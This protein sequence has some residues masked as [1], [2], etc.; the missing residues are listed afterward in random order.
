MNNFSE[1]AVVILNYNGRDF[2][3]KYLPSVIQ[4]SGNAQIIVADN[5][6]TDDSLEV[7]KQDFPEINTIILPENYWFAKGYNQALQQVEA[8]YFVLLNSDVRVTE[9]WLMPMLNLLES[10]S[11]IAA[12]Q[13]KILDDK[14]PEYFEY[15]SPAGG[16]IDYLGYPF[17]R[18]R[19][20][21]T[22]E[23]DEQQYNDTVEVFWACGAC[24]F[25]RADIFREMGGFD[26]DFFA[27]QEEIDLCWRI[28]NAG[29]K[30]YTCGKST[31]YH[32]GGGT[33]NYASFRKTF[34]NFRNSLAMVYKNHEPEGLAKDIFM[35]LILDGVAGVKFLL[36]GSFTGCWAI[37]RAHFNFYRHFGMWKLKR[38]ET[39]KRVIK[40]KHQEIYQKSIVWEY[41]V[42][43]KKEY[44]KLEEK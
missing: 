20:F 31:I 29:Y 16:F 40:S 42:K 17:C 1:I 34:L 14:S 21:D 27:H 2:L 44:R 24:M 6:S 7:M 25:I 41:F 4:Y 39:Q 19:I 13:P 11:S 26:D 36:S 28:K 43:G 12:C 23:K 15:A 18:G 8:K 9:N 33:L 5:A 22:V 10:D 35:R 32:W 37:I 3:R 38:E 30:I